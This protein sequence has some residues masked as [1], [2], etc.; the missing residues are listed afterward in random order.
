MDD[1]QRLAR[2]NQAAGRAIA[3]LRGAFDPPDGTDLH[4]FPHREAIARGYLQ[5]IVDLCVGEQETGTSSVAQII[6][7]YCHDGIHV[8]VINPFLDAA[9]LCPRCGKRV[10]VPAQRRWKNY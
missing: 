10:S 1:K 9:L 8:G 3:A 6:C 7:P 2:I 4:D 5:E